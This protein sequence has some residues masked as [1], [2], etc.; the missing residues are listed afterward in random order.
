[1]YAACSIQLRRYEGEQGRRGVF[2][3]LQLP[4]CKELHCEWRCY[5]LQ[6]WTRADEKF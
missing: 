5:D 2:T 3:G 1:M 4:N 6:L